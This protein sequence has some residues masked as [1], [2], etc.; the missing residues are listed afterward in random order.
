M[1]Q[2]EVV[3]NYVVSASITAGQPLSFTTPINL[4]FAPDIIKLVTYHIQDGNNA[5]PYIL[6]TNLLNDDV[7]LG[8]S[9]IGVNQQ[10]DYLPTKRIFDGNFNF[11]LLQYNAGVLSQAN[12]TGAP[13]VVAI[14]FSFI[15]YKHLE[16]NSK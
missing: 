4:T 16:K 5:N 6:K 10:I 3:K 1:S 13:A 14:T 9:G 15:K 12:A 2:I 8:N 11:S 7:A